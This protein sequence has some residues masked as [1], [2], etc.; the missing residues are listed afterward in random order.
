MSIDLPT[1]LYI[2]NQKLRD[3]ICRLRDKLLELAKECA[4]CDGTGLASEI[5]YQ[6]TRE[7]RTQTAVRTVECETCRDIRAALE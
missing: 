3:Q 7:G 1:E 5:E 6:H 2:E 4:S